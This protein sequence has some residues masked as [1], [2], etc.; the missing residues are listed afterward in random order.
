MRPPRRF[1]SQN[2]LHELWVLLRFLFPD[3]FTTSA[4]FDDCFD[5][6]RS[7]VD[8]GML[9]A[10]SH[11][12][13]LF[14]LRRLKTEVELSLPPKHELKIAVPLSEFQLHFYKVQ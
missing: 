12:L 2:N 8:Q 9:D 5:L 7:K 1:A 13:R 3:T 4:P 11:L 14:C 6:G 10:A